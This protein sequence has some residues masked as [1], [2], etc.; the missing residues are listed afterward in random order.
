MNRT[1]Y[2]VIV[3]FTEIM[4]LARKQTCV[5]SAAAYMNVSIMLTWCGHLAAIL[6]VCVKN[7]CIT[8]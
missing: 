1:V 6:C 4:I 2:H 8:M 5:L 7:T 3:I